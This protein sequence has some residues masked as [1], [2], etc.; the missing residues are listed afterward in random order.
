MSDYQQKNN[1]GTLFKNDYKK[2]DNHPDYKGK[3]MVNGKEME[4]AAWL[5]D[6]QKGKYMS[7]SFSEP[8]VPKAQEGFDP[9]TGTGSDPMPGDD[10]N[11]DIPF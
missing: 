6:G 2:A 4:F 9:N 1:T 3:C 7:F 8:F 5:K 11:A 10:L